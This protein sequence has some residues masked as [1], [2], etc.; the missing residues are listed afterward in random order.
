MMDHLQRLVGVRETSTHI[1]LDQ[2]FSARSQT[3]DFVSQ[4]TR[5]HIQLKSRQA[6]TLWRSG[7][8]LA[9]WRKSLMD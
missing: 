7:V 2:L 6:F 3:L 4:S 5:L 1:A 8:G 9:P